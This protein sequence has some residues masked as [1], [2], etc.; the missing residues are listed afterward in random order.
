MGFARYSRHLVRNPSPRLH[1]FQSRMVPCPFGFRRRSFPLVLGPHAP[2][3]L[4]FTMGPPRPHCRSDA[5][6]LF[7]QWGVPVASA[8]RCRSLLRVPPPPPELPLPPP[9]VRRQLP[10]PRPHSR[11]HPPNADHPPHR[12]WRLLSFRLL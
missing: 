6:C 5:R 3:S 2:L 9:P 12:F 7:P 1:V 11:Q 4:R 10:L 8:P